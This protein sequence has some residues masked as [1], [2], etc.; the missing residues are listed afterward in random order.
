MLEFWNN[1]MHDQDTFVNA[2][3]LTFLMIWGGVILIV[4]YPGRP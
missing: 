2:L 1:F 3:A 4:T